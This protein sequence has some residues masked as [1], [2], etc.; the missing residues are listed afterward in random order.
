VQKAKSALSDIQKFLAVAGTSPTQAVNRLA[1]FA[2]DITTAFNQ[3]LGNNVFADLA[4]FR[5]VGQV[6]FAEAS[7][8]LNPGL[9]SQPQAMLTLDILN[10]APPRTFQLPAFLNGTLPASQDIAV[11]QRL[12]SA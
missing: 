2:A 3:L 4:S 6:V 7:R 12:V 9:S 10:A 1:Q 11:E 5:A 8:A